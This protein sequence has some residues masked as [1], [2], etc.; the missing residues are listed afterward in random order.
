[1]SSRIT[2]V[3]RPA[4]HLNTEILSC[5]FAV[6]C[7]ACG[8]FPLLPETSS[9]SI[10]TCSYNSYYFM[11]HKF[12]FSCS[13]QRLIF[14]HRIGYQVLNFTILNIISNRH[15]PMHPRSK[16]SQPQNSIE[17]LWFL[18]VTYQK[19]KTLSSTNYHLSS[20][21]HQSKLLKCIYL[22]SENACMTDWH[23]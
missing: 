7:F 10:H 4:T 16:M 22:E 20:S 15:I 23:I 5:G 2:G 11:A 8:P 9:V 1:M 17:F 19:K 6:P 13:I 12:T 3:K 21:R 14:P 18:K